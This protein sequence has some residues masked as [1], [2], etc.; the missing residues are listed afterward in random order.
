MAERTAIAWAHSTF[1]PWL[2]CTKVGP[3]CDHCYAELLDRNRFSHTLGPWT[4]DVPRTQQRVI[5]WGAGAPRHRT[6]VANWRLPVKW[7]RMAAASGEPWRVFCASL[8]DV[9][10]NEVPVAWRMEL[11]DLIRRTPALTWML[12]TKRIG[13]AEAM[14]PGGWYA[15]GEAP[16]GPFA[17]VWLGITVVNQEEADRDIPKLLAIPARVR[18]LSCEPLLGWLDLRRYL[19][20]LSAGKPAPRVDWVIVGGESGKAARPMDLNWAREIRNDC[21]SHGVPLFVKQMG[22][23][24]G[25]KDRAGANPAEWPDEYRIREFPRRPIAPLATEGVPTWST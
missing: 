13:N 8:A 7:N 1:N 3:G 16:F 18:W 20:P 24:S 22:S 17:N 19:V 21:L 11:F 10:D 5:H 6:S 2:G 23:G 9:F 12:L 4:G 14:L 25:F 15:G